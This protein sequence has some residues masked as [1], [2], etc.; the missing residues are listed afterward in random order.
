MREGDFQ[1]AVEE[2]AHARSLVERAHDPSAERSLALQRFL[3]ARLLGFPDGER[4]PMDALRRLLPDIYFGRELLSI[5][6]GV[7]RGTTGDATGGREAIPDDAIA[8]AL[9][10]DD[11][12]ILD[13]LAEIA[14]TARDPE[15][16]REVYDQTVCEDPITFASWGTFGMASGPPRAHLA[17]LGA[18]ACER[19][20]DAFAA[21]ERAYRTASETNARPHAV[22][23]MLRHAE[24]L[25]RRGG[26][27]DRERARAKSEEAARLAAALGMEFVRDRALALVD[28][29]PS[30]EGE[31]AAAL[32]EATFTLTR[33]GEGY[34]IEHGGRSFLLKDTKG[35]RL[36]EK[37]VAEP[38][39]EHHVLDLS[40]PTGRRVVTASSDAG[41]VIDAQARAAYRKRLLDLRAELE[42]AEADED[43]GR[44]DR[45]RGEIRAIEAELK[46]ALGL[47]GKSRKAASDAERARVNV[48]RRIKDAIKRVEA[49]DEDLARHL[50][51]A[52][53]TGTLC[54]Y[55]PW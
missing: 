51:W 20:D 15:L 23:A 34:R 5:V 28:A 32:P 12:S 19:W 29:A 41:E 30:R 6:E 7:L 53:R 2:N 1:R 8:T 48:Q 31:T 42:E 52:I 21:F 22:W 49:Q 40:S 10:M 38:G 47:G 14:F 24:T 11:S 54:S 26:P 45:V 35:V 25:V 50:D 4:T 44:R 46:S 13:C 55:R 3:L 27:G 9:T 17:G 36:L 43:L 18:A 33:D 39:R 37:L 16:G